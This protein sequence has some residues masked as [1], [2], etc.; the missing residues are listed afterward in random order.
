MKSLTPL[1]VSKLVGGELVN[2]HSFKLDEV[3]SLKYASKSSISFFLN[4]IYFEDL[5]KSKAGLILVGEDFVIEDDKT[6]LKHPSASLAFS[7]LTDYFAPEVARYPKFIHPTAVLGEGIFI[8]KGVHIGA[9]VTIE[10]GCK[11]GA[12]TVILPHTYIGRNTEIGEGAFI[13]SNV[14]LIEYS[15]VGARCIL[16]SGCVIGS[17]GFGFISGKSG[18]TKI[19]QTGNVV[20][21]DDVEIGAGSTLDRARFASTIIGKGTKIDNLVHIAHNVELGEHCFLAAQVGIAGST[22]IGD[23]VQMGGKSGAIGHLKIGDYSS[24]AVGT[25]V[26]RDVPANSYMVGILPA[27]NKREHVA[28][29]TAHK[30]VESLAKELRDKI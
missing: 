9:Y 7:Q 8:G 29:I 25:I 19:R 18:H 17:D 30:K 28:R 6:Y 3:N 10:D 21:G 13:Y 4:K 11:I 14:S 12:S 1:E 26:T 20:L 22:I 2:S 23:F 24:I 16:H 5:N 15:V 27:T